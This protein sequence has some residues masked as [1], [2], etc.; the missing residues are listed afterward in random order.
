MS[1]RQGVIISIVVETGHI[2]KVKDI[3]NKNIEKNR[4][5]RYISDDVN[6]LTVVRS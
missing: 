2:Q 4:A 6:P 3:M 1:I 5:L